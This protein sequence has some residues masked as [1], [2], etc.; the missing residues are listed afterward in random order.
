MDNYVLEIS[1]KDFLGML[2]NY[3]TLKNNKVIQVKEKHRLV[4]GSYGCDSTVSVEIYYEEEKEILGY[5]AIKTTTLS[6]EEIQEILKELLD[7]EDY[8]VDSL[9]YKTRTEYR[10]GNGM[11]E[12]SYEVAVFDGV[13]INIIEKE[14]QLRRRLI[15]KHLKE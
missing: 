7:R 6:K 1:K 2:S 10:S 15:W 3:F 5:N 14:N 11:Y 12:P 8:I 13:K 4:Q 9:M